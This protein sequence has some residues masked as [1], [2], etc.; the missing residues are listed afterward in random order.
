MLL[1]A[2]A[3]DV[4]EPTGQDELF[5]IETGLPPAAA[6]AALAERVATVDRRRLDRRPGAQ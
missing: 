2:P 4:R 5:L 1:H 6:L 3:I